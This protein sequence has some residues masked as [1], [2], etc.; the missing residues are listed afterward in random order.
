MTQTP[1]TLVGVSA[2]FQRVLVLADGFARLG[3]EVLLV[4]ATGVGK[5]MIARRIHAARHL[6]GQ[7][8]SV[9]GGELHESTFHDA[10]FGHVRGAF[11]DAKTPRK[12]AFELAAAGSLFLDELPHWSR[13]A[14]SALLVPLGERRI[15]ALG[16]EH[17]IAV[18]TRLLV[19]STTHPDQL[20]AQ[21][22]LL[23]DLR[24]RLPAHEIT[25]PALVER[26]AD[27]LP[28]ATSFL[29]ELSLRTPAIKAALFEPEVVMALLGHDW[30]G[31]VRELQSAVGSSA[32]LA[33]VE[34]TEAVALRHLPASIAV[35]GCRLQDL[36][37]E[38]ADRT[39]EW[40]LGRTG[41]NQ[42]K[43]ARLLTIHRNTVARRR[44]RRT[45][46]AQYETIA[47][48]GE[49]GLPSQVPFDG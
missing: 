3:C 28:L 32:A 15:V 2:A 26:R 4:G 38:A 21:G 33:T 37:D 13:I 17:A 9:S 8:I 43:A 1:P 6:S 5:G 47:P 39:M 20:L 14:Q 23:A 18:D 35:R 11:T 45:Q 10:L 36:D 16:S 27:I 12:G 44:K 7:L 25:I 22:V 34:G 46:P 48:A 19:G 29:D 49:P 41:G 24:Y 31:N 40:A 30:P 42:V